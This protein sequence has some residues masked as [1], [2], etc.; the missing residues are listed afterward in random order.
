MFGPFDNLLLMIIVD[1]QAI[2]FGQCF[3]AFTSHE[4][5]THLGQLFAGRHVT[6]FFEQFFELFLPSVRARVDDTDKIRRYELESKERKT[7]YGW[8]LVTRN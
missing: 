6:S 7:Q 1:L 2:V 3:E 4:Q 8:W 5:H